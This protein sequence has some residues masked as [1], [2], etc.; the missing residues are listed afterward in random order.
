MPGNHSDWNKKVV[1]TLNHNKPRD[2]RQYDI[3]RGHTGLS[4]LKKILS[5]FGCTLFSFFFLLLKF[6]GKNFKFRNLNN[7]L[8]IYYRSYLFTKSYIYK[9][10]EKVNHRHF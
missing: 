8:K 3:L 7:F 2:F 9:S 5:R 10:L 6:F 1:I 4:R